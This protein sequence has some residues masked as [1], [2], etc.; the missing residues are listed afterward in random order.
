MFLVGKIIEDDSEIMNF[1]KELATY[2]DQV[3][4]LFP[5]CDYWFKTRHND[6]NHS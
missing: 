2:N 3:N 5:L 4:I 1:V 6:Y